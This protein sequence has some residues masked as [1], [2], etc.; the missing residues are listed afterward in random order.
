[1]CGLHWCLCVSPGSPA[2]EAMKHLLPLLPRDSFQSSW[3][4]CTTTC[5]LPARLPPPRRKGKWRIQK[6]QDC[7]PEKKAPTKT[8]QPKCSQIRQAHKSILERSLVW[9]AGSLPNSLFTYPSCLSCALPVKGVFL[10]HCFSTGQ[11]SLVLAENCCA[12]RQQ[13]VEA[14]HYSSESHVV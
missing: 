7:M 4:A 13:T 14:I 12:K 6:R 10:T 2:Q 5:C 3:T 1:M 9:L 11:S 8:I